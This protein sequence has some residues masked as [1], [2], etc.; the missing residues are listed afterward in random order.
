MTY[1]NITTLYKSEC[2]ICGGVVN[3]STTNLFTDA[4]IE[5]IIEGV[6]TGLYTPDA[7]PE[8]YYVR[9]ADALYSAVETGFGSTLL[10]LELGGVDYALLA[11]LQTNTYVFSAA[12]TYQQIKDMQSLLVKYKDE[13]ALFK[14]E[15]TKLFND[16]NTPKGA[17]Y[18]SAEYATAKSSAY[19]AKNWI[20]IQADKDIFPLLQYQTVGD[21]RVRPSHV[22]LDN[23]IR[24]VDDAFWNS[25]YP[26]N[27]WRC[28]CTVDKLTD[29]KE[30][31]M[32]GFKKPND[33]PDIF[34]MN[35]GKDKVIFSEKHPYF[36]VAKGDKE[37]AL[38][39][40]NLPLP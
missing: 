34:L 28:R 8:W 10:E 13:P 11:E 19:S 4:E 17:N 9:V 1:E 24:P 26:P 14:K 2:N 35:A 25:Y 33:V 21:A 5:D 23:I 30:T 6:E 20:G 39:N 3:A 36:E 29:G 18:L 31:D 40:F 27:G 38:N 12:K 16:Y 7:L 32:T 37:L 22:E 15:A